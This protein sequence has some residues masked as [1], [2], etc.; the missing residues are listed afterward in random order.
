MSDGRR[1]PSFDPSTEKISLQGQ[2][3]RSN[4]LITSKYVINRTSSRHK[5]EKK[6]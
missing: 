3:N 6:S 5:I 2:G 1:F 4:K